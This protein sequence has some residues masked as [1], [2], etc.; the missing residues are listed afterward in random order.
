[1]L[2]I[3]HVTVPIDNVVLIGVTMVPVV[4]ALQQQ[5]KLVLE[6]LLIESMSNSCK[7]FLVPHPLEM[8]HNAL[9]LAQ[10]VGLNKDLLTPTSSPGNVALLAQLLHGKS[11]L[12]IKGVTMDVTRLLPEVLPPGLE[13][14]AEE[15]TIV[16]AMP[17]MAANLGLLAPPLHGNSNNN[18]PLH[19]LELPFLAILVMQLLVT[20]ADTLLSKQWVL[21]LDLQLLL[22]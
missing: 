15:A 8:S 10:Q 1:M 17:I 14:V 12:V 4:L 16:A 20:L 21:H 6:M 3:W 7:N 5:V 9:S 11:A 18:K 13:I 2:V 19:S 22:D